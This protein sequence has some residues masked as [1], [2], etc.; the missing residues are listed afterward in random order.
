MKNLKKLKIK[1]K[2]FIET[3]NLFTLYIL[4]GLKLNKN[5]NK[6]PLKNVYLIFFN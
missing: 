5:M 6:L 4:V 2:I 3:K 1:F